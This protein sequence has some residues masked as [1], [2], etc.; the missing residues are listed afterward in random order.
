MT[1]NTTNLKKL[2]GNFSTVPT[3]VQLE[4][5]TVQ[6]SSMIESLSK[7]VCYKRDFDISID[8]KTS[9]ISTLTK[10]IDNLRVDITVLQS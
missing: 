8:Q 1:T 4:E 10:K 5:T 2:Y 7:V 9:V 3:K 6:L